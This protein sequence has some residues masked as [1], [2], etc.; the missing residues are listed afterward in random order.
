MN[1][2][3]ETNAMMEKV[4]STLMCLDEKLQELQQRDIIVPH[5]KRKINGILKAKEKM[6]VKLSYVLERQH[7]QQPLQ[8]KIEQQLQYLLNKKTK[9]CP[10]SP[11]FEYPKIEFDE[12]FIEYIVTEFPPPE[13]PEPPEPFID[14]TK[15][16]TEGY[17]DI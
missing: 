17:L 14:W 10:T 8:H 9:S 15:E 16:L 11:T 5:R 3:T 1:F 2:Q 4:H 6:S 7:L 12:E 13:P